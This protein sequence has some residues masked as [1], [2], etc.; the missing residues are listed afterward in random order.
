[1]F[2]TFQ[3]WSQR[4]CARAQGG[5]Q[6]KVFVDLVCRWR[7]GFAGWGRAGNQFL[8]FSRWTLVHLYVP[9][10]GGDGLSEQQVAKGAGVADALFYIRDPD[11]Q[12]GTW[13]IWQHY[14][15]IKSHCAQPAA[16]RHR[17]LVWV[18]RDDFIHSWMMQ[19]KVFE[20]FR[21]EQCDV[22]FG[23]M[24]AQAEQGGGG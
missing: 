14:G 17:T 9:G 10:A 22:S 20:L 23:K 7:Q 4:L 21:R 2:G 12:G 3:K 5:D 16:D 19:P 24:F 11:F 15:K 1:M 6:L 8:N 13:G 18:E